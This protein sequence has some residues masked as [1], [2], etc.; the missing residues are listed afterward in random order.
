MDGNFKREQQGNL[1]T[2]DRGMKM[3]Q[4]RSMKIKVQVLPELTRNNQVRNN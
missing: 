2:K 1:K 4:M 3:K